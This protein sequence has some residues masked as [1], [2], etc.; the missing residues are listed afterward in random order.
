MKK[1][2]MQVSEVEQ[3]LRRSWADIAS[4]EHVYG[5]SGRDIPPESPEIQ[6]LHQNVKLGHQNM[7]C[8]T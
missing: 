1:I 6:K 8:P 4:T 7:Q 2:S 3:G 5:L